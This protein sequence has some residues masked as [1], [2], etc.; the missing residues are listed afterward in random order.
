VPTNSEFSDVRFDKSQS[1]ER[2]QGN[3]GVSG[4]HGYD[5]RPADFAAPPVTADIYPNIF[6]YG[7]DSGNRMFSQDKENDPRALL[8]ST[9]AGVNAHADLNASYG[10]TQPVATLGSH[11][12]L[13]D[14]LANSSEREAGNESPF[15]DAKLP[16]VG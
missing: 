16:K 15:T 2:Q 8:E 12:F 4:E 10:L 1:A 7:Y 14:G 3:L 6:N 5:R 11:P 9:R 13:R